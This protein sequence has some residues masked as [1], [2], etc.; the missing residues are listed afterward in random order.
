MKIAII[1][2][3]GSGKSTLG[4][5]LHKK[6][7]IPL[8]Y[9]DQYYWKPGWQK[10]ESA[11]FEKE[12]HQ[13]CD[14]D[15]WIIEGV[16]TRLFD[17]RASKADVIIFLDISPWLCLYRVFKRCLLNFGKV[18]DSSAPGCHEIMPSIQFLKFIW[19]F[20]KERKPLIEDLL[21]KYSTTK[22]IFIVK[23]TD[24]FKK[25]VQQS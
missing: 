16:A 5:T 25:V 10:P 19:R 18:R 2:N 7:G 8:Y 4:E 17:Y 3:A 21:E 23:N 24:D 9:L 6:L 15:E 22:K 20:D 14:K 12:H 13:L 11:E 1:G